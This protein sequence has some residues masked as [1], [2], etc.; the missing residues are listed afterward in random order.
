MGTETAVIARASLTSS[1]GFVLPTSHQIITRTKRLTEGKQE[2]VGPNRTLSD[3]ASVPPDSSFSAS[4]PCDLANDE[5]LSEIVG[6]ALHLHSS[7]LVNTMFVS[8][9][10]ALQNVRPG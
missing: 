10:V 4:H 8:S 1:D 2:E 9:T 6:S 3:Q 7:R 5:G